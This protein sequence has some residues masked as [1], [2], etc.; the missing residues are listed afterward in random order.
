MKVAAMDRGL[1]SADLAL[2][3]LL[4]KAGPHAFPLVPDEADDNATFHAEGLVSQGLIERAAALPNTGTT[5]AI[6]LKGRF[7][8]DRFLSFG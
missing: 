3:Q 4:I 8:F 2:L 7:V 5:Y 6:T 1:S